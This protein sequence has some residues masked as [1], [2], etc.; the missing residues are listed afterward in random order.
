MPSFKPSIILR[1]G[2]T[3]SV[4][5]GVL[6]LGV[7]YL[8]SITIIPADVTIHDIANIRDALLKFMFLGGIIGGM[9]LSAAQIASD[10]LSGN[11]LLSTKR[12]T[13]T[14]TQN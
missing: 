10:L 13:P 14:T 4:F 7:H 5:V 3:L 2:I 12:S 6:S 9:A 1:A 11:P 8:A